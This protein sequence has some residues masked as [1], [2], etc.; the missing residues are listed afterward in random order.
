ML[1]EH[2]VGNLIS[3]PK[4]R[5]ES[6]VQTL[7]ASSE[8]EQSMVWRSLL[9]KHVDEELN[10]RKQQVDKRGEVLRNVLSLKL[11]DGQ[12]KELLAHQDRYAGFISSILGHMSS[13]SSQYCSLC[14]LLIYYISVYYMSH[15]VYI[16]YLL[17]T[18]YNY[19]LYTKSIYTMYY[20]CL[21]YKEYICYISIYY[22]H[23]EMKELSALQTKTSLNDKRQCSSDKAFRPKAEVDRRLKEINDINT[24]KFS[25]ERQKLKYKHEAQIEHLKRR[26][27]SE[28]QAIK[29]LC[30]EEKSRVTKEGNPEV[31]E[32]IETVM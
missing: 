26:H 22:T 29:E 8:L 15:R 14:L 25:L 3:L 19:I 4:S 21:L 28:L 12:L 30:E 2:S 13:I 6:E 11:H 18:E 31:L 23:R 32:K 24:K 5:S 10:V 16:L 1:F 7:P 17:Y 20:I 27:V 9:A